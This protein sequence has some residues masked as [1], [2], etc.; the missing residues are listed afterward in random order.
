MTIE[1]QAYFN[2]LKENQCH[3]LCSSGKCKA[4]CCGC[5]DMLESYFKLL[6]KYIPLSKEYKIHK[7]KHNGYKYVKPVTLDYKC[8]FLSEENSCLIHDSHLRPKICQEFGMDPTEPLK[9]CMHINEESAEIIQEFAKTQLERLKDQ[10][11]PLAK[12]IL[13]GLQ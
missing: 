5:I 4:D 13:D 9:A 3:E 6:K 7:Y 12:D 10:G 1:N 11:N 2:T 8:V